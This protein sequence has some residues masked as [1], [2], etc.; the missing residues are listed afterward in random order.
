M[1]YINISNQGPLDEDIKMPSFQRRM[2]LVTG[3]SEMF[4]TGFLHLCNFSCFSVFLNPPHP[5]TLLSSQSDFMKRVAM[6]MH[7]KMLLKLCIKLN[8]A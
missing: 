2:S 5:S 3:I 7:I 6:K 4:Q 1:C 8:S